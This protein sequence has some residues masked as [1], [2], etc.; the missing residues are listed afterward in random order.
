MPKGPVKWVADAVRDAQ[1]DNDTA[2]VKDE[3]T[4]DPENAR[5]LDAWADEV[6]SNVF[7]AMEDRLEELKR[8]KR[9]R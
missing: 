4:E 8:R 1:G 7:P 3:D 9:R 5:E 6:M 2:F